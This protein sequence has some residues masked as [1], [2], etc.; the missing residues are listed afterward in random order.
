MSL[1]IPLEPPL[2]VN[3]VERKA[4]KDEVSAQLAGEAPLKVSKVVVEAKTIIG[5]RAF[6][7]HERKRHDLAPEL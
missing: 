7:V 1:H 6:G 2:V 4:E 5:Q 3:R